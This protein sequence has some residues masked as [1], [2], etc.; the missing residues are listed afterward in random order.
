M[1]AVD[2][3]CAAAEQLPVPVVLEHIVRPVL[4][5]LS[6]GP[7]AAV[8][9]VRIGGSMGGEL[10]AKHLLEPLLRVLAS[11]GSLPAKHSAEQLNTGGELIRWNSVNDCF[12]V[13]LRVTKSLSLCGLYDSKLRF[14]FHCLKV[15]I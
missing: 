6:S 15:V 1:Q 14:E 10:A 4:L 2:A 7:H 8:A 13:F 11:S 9:L 12:A 3:L 5:S